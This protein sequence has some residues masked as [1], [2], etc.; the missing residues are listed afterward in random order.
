MT[1][2]KIKA[3]KAKTSNRPKTLDEIHRLKI[4]DFKTRK[5]QLPTKKNKLEQSRKL[6]AQLILS[7]I[8]DVDTAER[9][10]RLQEDI[11]DL[12]RFIYDVEND[13]SELE[14][15]SMAGEVLMD[16]YD[17]IEEGEEA[18]YLENPDLHQEIDEPKEEKK[19]L[20]VLDMLNKK[21]KKTKR[22]KKNTRKRKRDV[23]MNNSLDIVT[24]MG[25]EKTE[26]IDTDK[27]SHATLYN[28]YNMYINKEYAQDDKYNKIISKCSKC[29]IDKT[30]NRS[31]GIC[32]CM[33]CGEVEML[34]IESEKSN[35]KDPTPEKP[36]YPYKRVNHFNE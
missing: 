26:D 14:Y 29:G 2:F 3:S 34:I 23:Q 10:V 16:F 7:G 22:K 35:Y 33:E 27:K 30:I 32:V 12:E 8:E 28:E 4:D 9:I 18:L 24:M 31:E 25:C 5:K 17:M 15:Y 6:L 1:M 20:D 13:V 36:G 11:Q 21:N 19:E